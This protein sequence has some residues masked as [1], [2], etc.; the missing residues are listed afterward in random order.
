MISLSRR[1]GSTV[2]IEY[3]IV[4]SLLRRVDYW[5]LLLVL[6]SCLVDSFELLTLVVGRRAVCFS[7]SVYNRQLFQK[8]FFSG[9]SSAQPYA[10]YNSIGRCWTQYESRVYFARFE[11][12]S[13]LFTRVRFYSIIG[14]NNTPTCVFPRI[15]VVVAFFANSLRELIVQREQPQ[16]QYIHTTCQCLVVISE[17]FTERENNVVRT[18]RL[19]VWV[20]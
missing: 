10:F 18:I 7:Y 1:S 9:V 19:C 20:C 16:Q 2:V 12:N 14:R 3:S 17:S 5:L 15:S 8:L 6:V 11:F 4:L 13:L